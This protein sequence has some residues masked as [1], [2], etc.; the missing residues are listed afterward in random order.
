VAQSVIEPC[1]KK[2]RKR[3]VCL[4]TRFLRDL[5]LHHEHQISNTAQFV[6]ETNLKKLCIPAFMMKMIIYCFD[7]F[8]FLFL[9]FALMSHIS[10][11]KGR[12]GMVG[13]KKGVKFSVLIVKY[14]GKYNL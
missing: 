13:D 14:I 6:S 2:S 11:F 5:F 10:A 8:C 4:R 3:A 1:L 7:A 12:E 9:N